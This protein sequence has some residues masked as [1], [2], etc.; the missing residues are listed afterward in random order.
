MVKSVVLGL[1]DVCM[2][3]I[4]SATR[5]MEEERLFKNWPKGDDKI[6]NIVGDYTAEQ[7]WY[8]W[9]K[10][11]KTEVFPVLGEILPQL[12]TNIT[13]ASFCRTRSEVAGK[14]VWVMENTLNI[15]FLAVTKL[16]AQHFDPTSV[17]ID[18]DEKELAAWK[19]P[20]V[21]VPRRWN[22]GE[23]SRVITSVL[24]QLQKLHREK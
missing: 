20:K 15:P 23:E 14:S 5:H 1:G 16:K 17:L 18:D 7:D 24:E 22:S 10:L 2:D 13:F 6:L 11:P 8:W 12:F 21:C 3:V 4:G 19:G 9:S